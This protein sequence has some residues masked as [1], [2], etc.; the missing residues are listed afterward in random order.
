MTKKCVWNLFSFH[1]RK[2]EIQM[3]LVPRKKFCCQSSVTIWF[4]MSTL[5]YM[6]AYKD[7]NWFLVTWWLFHSYTI[8]IFICYKYLVFQK[9]KKNM[10]S[11]PQMSY[12]FNPSLYLGHIIYILKLTQ[13]RDKPNFKHYF[14]TYI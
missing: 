11:F 4:G 3:F 13:M 8:Y 7:I 5:W 10:F 1:I 9:K 14:S 6:K 2:T 12:I